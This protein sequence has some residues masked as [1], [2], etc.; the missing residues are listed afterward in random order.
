MISNFQYARRTAGILK[1]ISIG[2]T[3]VM[4]VLAFVG[5]FYSNYTTN[6][7]EFRS[8]FTGNE[9]RSLWRE[10]FMLGVCVICLAVSII[11][12]FVHIV[13]RDLYWDKRTAIYDFMYHVGSVIL[14]GA[15]GLLYVVSA[16]KIFEI[17]CTTENECQHFEVKLAATALAL[18]LVFVNGTIAA[19]VLTNRKD[20]ERD[21]LIDEKEQA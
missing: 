9:V 11:N 15:G 14:I 1:M 10:Y 4:T 18:F 16:V 5:H 12:L 7:E 20:V 6:R 13:S 21:A 3:T 19:V 2:L 17:N 8:Q